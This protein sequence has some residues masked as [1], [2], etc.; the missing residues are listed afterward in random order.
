MAPSALDILARRLR[1][2]SSL[3]HIG[4]EDSTAPSWPPPQT[5]SV[6]EAMCSL[7]AGRVQSASC[8][9]RTTRTIM[10]IWEIVGHPSSDTPLVTII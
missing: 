2:W 7:A 10:G 5:A 1:T 4:V 3:T 6:R 9:N 8:K